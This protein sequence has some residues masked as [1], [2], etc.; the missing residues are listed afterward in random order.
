VQLSLQ[1]LHL[2]APNEEFDVSLGIG[3][4][5]TDD[6][7]RDP[8]EIEVDQE[9]HDRRSWHPGSNPVQPAS[10]RTGWSTARSQYWRPS[11]RD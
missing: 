8:A 10:T 9:D 11:P 7:L 1:G 3:A 6:H 4:P 5:P 2:V